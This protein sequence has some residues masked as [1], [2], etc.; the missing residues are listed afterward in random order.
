MRGAASWT[1]IKK[2]SE[3]NSGKKKGMRVLLVAIAAITGIVALSISGD[4]KYKTGI[5]GNTIHLKTAGFVVEQVKGEA[6][7]KHKHEE[8]GSTSFI[9]NNQTLFNISHCKLSYYGNVFGILQIEA[10][11]PL[12][13]NDDKVEIFNS[14][15]QKMI[16]SYEDREGYYGP[17]LTTDKDGYKRIELGTN[18]GAVG[19]SANITQYE[20]K[21]VVVE[22][23]C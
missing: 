10:Q 19:I 13:D 5:E 14:I 15:V 3:M 8:S 20:N 23:G 7:E 9:Y 11:I 2:V 12:E 16:E 6:D 4:P 17:K 22:A 18:L 21:I 1:Y